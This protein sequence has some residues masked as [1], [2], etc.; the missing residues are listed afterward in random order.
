MVRV[1]LGDDE[2]VLGGDGSATLQMYL[3]PLYWTLK[4]S[5]NDKQY[6]LYIYHNK[7]V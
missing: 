4:D 6:V 2:K 5:Y 7:I 3:M 1:F